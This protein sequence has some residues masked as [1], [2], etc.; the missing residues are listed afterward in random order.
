[1]RIKRF[2]RVESAS[3]LSSNKRELGSNT[4]DNVLSV[5]RGSW[6]GGCFSL[7]PPSEYICF[8]PITLSIVYLQ[9]PRGDRV[10]RIR[11]GSEGVSREVA[12]LSSLCESLPRNLLFF[13]YPIAILN[14]KP[15]AAKKKKGNLIWQRKCLRFFFFSSVPYGI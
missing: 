12:F 10:C 1:M 14:G 8:L 3:C 6:G 7:F 2:H 9:I 15:N 4:S 5:P 11:Y 13:C